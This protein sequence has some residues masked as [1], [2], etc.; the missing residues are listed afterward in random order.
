MVVYH[1]A[2]DPLDMIRQMIDAQAIIDIEESDREELPGYGEHHDYGRQVIYG[3]KF[4]R[5][6]K[7]SPDTVEHVELPIHFE[8][9]DVPDLPE[10]KDWEGEQRNPVNDEPPRERDLGEELDNK[11]GRPFGIES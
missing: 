4:K 10:L 1:E 7:K 3:Q 11:I 2:S 8:P 6:P 5:V 9:S